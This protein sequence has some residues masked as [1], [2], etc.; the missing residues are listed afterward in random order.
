MCVG[1]C[2]CIR[3]H[4]GGVCE[5]NNISNNKYPIINNNKHT[6]MHTQLSVI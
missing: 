5:E 2:A 3:T 1:V 4:A 6:H